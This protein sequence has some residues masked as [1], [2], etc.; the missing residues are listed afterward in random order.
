MNLNR[1]IV[2]LNVY[3]QMTK[4]NRMYGKSSNRMSTGLKVNSA[5]EDAAGLAIGNK[6]DSARRT[7]AKVE[8]NANDGISLIQT[9]DGA[10]ASVHEMLQ[11]M[12]ELSVQAAND[13]L[14]DE[15]RR[16]IQIE[17]NQLKEEITDLSDRTDFNTL[18]L[19]NG[20]G[21]RLTYDKSGAGAVDSNLS[22][23]GYVSGQVPEGSLEYKIESYGT[24][25]VVD[26]AES[27]ISV[28]ITGNIEIA[29]SKI[30]FKGTESRDEVISAIKQACEDNNIEYYPNKLVSMEQGSDQEIKITTDLKS[31]SAGLSDTVSTG[32]DAVIT[33]LKL[34]SRYDME[35]NADASSAG[36]KEFLSFN[37]GA[38]VIADGNKVYV[39]STNGQKVE[40]N[41]NVSI[42][43]GTG[44]YKINGALTT[45]A[46]GS[47]LPA[48]GVL[49][50]QEILDDGQVK[51]QVGTEKGAEI[52]IYT[53]EID[54]ESIGVKYINV[55]TREG[56]ER[57]ITETTAAIDKITEQ[58][59]LL[60]AY[61][62]RLEFTVETLTA[63]G[64]NTNQAYSRIMDTDMALEMSNLAQYNVKIQAAL[65]ILAQANQRP[66][67]LLQLLG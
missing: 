25:A 41:L 8:N 65:S 36:A 12:R 11:K 56:A 21:K 29:N 51:L 32:T 14:A 4:S 22:E 17:I 50:R 54:A 59:T 48:G 45:S 38:N 20:D 44:D 13:T 30:Y 33:G 7:I 40:I 34:Y 6:L 43:K 61:Q 1:N 62:N 35:A 52:S 46:P 9:V 37:Q 47:T 19:L 28:P 64:V 42:D 26:F 15:D 39:N 10:M 3:N 58:R 27:S 23:I 57:A 5:K 2:A 55:S 16:K 66:Q 60:G 31:G 67:Q 24:S 53:R 18:K 49:Q 63:Q